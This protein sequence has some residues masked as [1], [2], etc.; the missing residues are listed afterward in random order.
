MSLF[1]DDLHEGDVFTTQGR[2]VTESD[3]VGFAGV[4]GDFNPIHL[5]A[6]Q[7]AASPFGQRIVYGLLVL[8]IATGL[9]DRLGLFRESMIAQLSIEDWRFSAPVF[10]GDTLHVE[11]RI[12]STRLTSAGDRG[13]VRRRISVLNHREEIVQTGIYTVM[14]R[15]WTE[16]E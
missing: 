7:A 15:R 1:F 13:V 8:S 10:I 3:V 9:I 14:I 4:S 11:V 6:V 12:E 5:D 2:T 16:E